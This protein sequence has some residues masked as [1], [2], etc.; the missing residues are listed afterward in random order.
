MRKLVYGLYQKYKLIPVPAKAS[1]WFLICNILQAGLSVLTTPIFTRL[2]STEEFGVFS[3]YNSWR[4]ILLIFTSLNL[5]YGVYNNAMIKYE[6]PKTR[7]QYTS[8]MIALYSLITLTF[9][10]FYIFTRNWCNH[11]LGMSTKIVFLLFLDLLFY[12]ALLFWSSR[13][14]FEF[15]Y[16]WLVIV[17]LLMSFT[18]II[19]GIISVNLAIHK[20]F[21]KIASGVIV[22][23][24][25]GAVFL[26]CYLVKGREFINW[27]YWSFALKF[28]IPLI[29]HY[30]SEIVLSQSDRIMI[31]K[32]KTF[33]DSANYTIAYSI[34]TILQLFM[35]AINASFL[36]W[37]YRCIKNKQYEAMKKMTNVLM[38]CIGGG[39][40]LVTLL[41][42][43]IIMIF[44]GAQYSNAIYVIPPIGLSVFFMFLYDI[45]ATLEFYYEK[46]IGIMI[47][48]VTAALLNVLLNGLFIPYYG[49]YAAGYTTL[50]CY[51][52]YA[53]FHFIFYKRLCKQALGIN[54]IYDGRVLLLGMIFMFLV[55]MAINVLYPYKLLRYSL[56]VIIIIILW[57][58]K[59]MFLEKY[60]EMKNTK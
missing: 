24:I 14:R 45:F 27:K 6:N 53:L 21:A 30:L 59:Y 23:A 35:S 54:E 50:F 36:P 22:N 29:P 28:N 44:A 40:L 7:D 48:S 32:Y 15:K 20:D 47:A 12:P 46:N 52:L 16:K 60:N 25:F 17:T 37:A 57:T 58:K 55:T 5:S 1:L 8:S 4:S 42:P 10:V 51:M 43:E 49:F 11:I 41:A 19:S 56:L 34:V 39:I 9:G 33:T 38:I 26:I 13:Q 2:M 18:S 3:T 31:S